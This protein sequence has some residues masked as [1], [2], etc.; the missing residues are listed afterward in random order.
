MP[1]QASTFGCGAYVNSCD[2][3]E[4]MANP[5]AQLSKGLKTYWLGMSW[6]RQNPKYLMMLL[7]PS[8]IG[9]LSVVLMFSSFWE[10]R[11]VIYDWVLFEPGESFLWVI[12]FNVARFFASVIIFILTLVSGLLVSNIISAPIYEVVSAAVERDKT[13][14]VVE[15]SLWESIKLIP[16]ELKKIVAILGVS[17][18]LML[19]PIVNFVAVFLTAFLIGWDFYDYPLARR[20]QSFRQRREAALK[21]FWSIMGLGLWLTIPGL[22]IFLYPFAVVGGTLLNLERLE[23][24][25]APVS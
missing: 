2:E 6:L 3:S 25:E 10:H 4:I 17:I 12:A 8:F 20:G 7:I 16:E 19:L 1:R 24:I 14:K 11:D 18:V 9:I 5:V 13:G 22:Q 15:I 23:K 21:D